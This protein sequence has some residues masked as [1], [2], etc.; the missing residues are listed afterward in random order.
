MVILIIILAIA[1]FVLVGSIMVSI[2][3]PSSRGGNK[4]SNQISLVLTGL[5]LAQLA[6]SK[7]L[8]SFWFVLIAIF[9]T[10]GTFILIYSLNN[11][12]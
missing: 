2:I 6:D 3:N 11:K 1:I 7:L 9:A 8:D 12:T 4:F 10:I 5:I